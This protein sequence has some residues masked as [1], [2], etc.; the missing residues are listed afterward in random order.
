MKMVLSPS[1]KFVKFVK[2]LSAQRAIVQSVEHV[3]AAT[4]IVGETILASIASRIVA[5]EQLLL[6]ENS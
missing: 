6:M 3:I 1:L 5:A 4:V 2:K